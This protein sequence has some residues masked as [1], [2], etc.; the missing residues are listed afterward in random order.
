MFQIP[1][2]ATFYQLICDL[3]RDEQMLRR[4]WRAGQAAAE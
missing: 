2:A 4:Q 3:Q 1:P